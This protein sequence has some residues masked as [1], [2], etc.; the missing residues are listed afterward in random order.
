MKA[1]KDWPEDIQRH[2]DESYHGDSLRFIEDSLSLFRYSND[3]NVLYAAEHCLP[4]LDQQVKGLVEK[5]LG[6]LP[7]HELSIGH[8]IFIRL[9]LYRYL[10]DVGISDQE[11]YNGVDENIRHIRNA[12]MKANPQLFRKYHVEDFR[13]YETHLS[14]Y[15]EL[16]RNK[17]AYILGYVPDLLYS[18]G[19]EM[20]FRELLAQLKPANRKLITPADY[21][22]AT[23]VKYREV[24]LTSGMD[25]A[26]ASPL[27]GIPWGSDGIDPV[28]DKFLN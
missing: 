26:D 10:N 14:E 24:Y 17:I 5:R 13:R 11:F 23:F 9:L 18:L 6:Y 28:D 16:A 4:E 8:E 3:W 20:H 2:I 25:A 22:T 15:K 19:P 1:D 21:R 7:T 12:D 27:V